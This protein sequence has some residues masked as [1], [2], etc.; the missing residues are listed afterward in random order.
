MIF[1]PLIVTLVTIHK[2]KPMPVFLNYFNT[3]FK[4]GFFEADSLTE[5]R[6]L[7][8]VYFR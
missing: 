8:L 7:S 6:T 4:V 5:P 1:S 2:A 3:F